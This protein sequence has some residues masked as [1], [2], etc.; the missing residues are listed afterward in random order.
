MLR[1]VLDGSST[2]VS[3]KNIVVS[4]PP[5]QLRLMSLEKEVFPFMAEA[6]ELFAFNLEGT[7]SQLCTITLYTSTLT[8]LCS[9]DV[10]LLSTT[11]LPSYERISVF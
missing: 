8:V 4:S 3:R 9:Y 7:H 6:G 11:M 10:L 2:V 1:V 5:L